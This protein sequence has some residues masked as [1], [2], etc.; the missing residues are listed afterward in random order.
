M[1][2]RSVSKIPVPQPRPRDLGVARQPDAAIDSNAARAE[3]I[4]RS[5]PEKQGGFLESAAKD[6]TP[7]FAGLEDDRHQQHDAKIEALVQQFNADKAK[8]VGATADQ[9]KGIPDMDPALMK[10][11]LIQ[12]TGGADKRSKA[13]WAKDPGQVNVPGDWG[14]PKADAEMGLKKPKKRNEGNLDT[15][16]KAA[17]VWLTRKGFSRSG[18]A[19]SELEGGQAFG[20]WKTALENYNGRADK[21]NGKKYKQAYAEKIMNRAANPDKAYPIQ[22]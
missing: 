3:S 22:F 2:S 18:K 8:F 6:L 4:K 17:L 10:S 1:S 15:N 5:G 13:A 12:E 21:V 19:P 16:M 9:A 7:T 14:A 11:W 20:G